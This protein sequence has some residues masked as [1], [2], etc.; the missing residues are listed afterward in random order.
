MVGGSEVGMEVLVV[1]LAARMTLWAVS[2][3]RSHPFVSFSASRWAVTTRRGASVVCS[4]VWSCGAGV[5]SFGRFTSVHH[6]NQPRA[7]FS[8]RRESGAERARGD[9]TAT[10]CRNSNTSS[11]S[12]AMVVNILVAA[13]STE[14]CF[15]LH[16]FLASAA[17]IVTT[18]SSSLALS[19]L[20]E[21][22]AFDAHS[23]MERAK[24][25][26][27]ST[28]SDLPWRIA[29]TVKNGVRRTALREV[30]S[31]CFLYHAR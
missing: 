13:V 27:S 25:F 23:V 2:G 24:I 6:W 20:L 28:R 3:R 4:R 30:Q 31:R 7:R 19:S 10:A 21:E 9:F 22:S 18:L 15:A 1:A 29:A 8:A 17:S 16:G 12:S 14:A 11:Q 5:G 26:R